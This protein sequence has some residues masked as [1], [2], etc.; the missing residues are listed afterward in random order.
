MS[1]KKW[2]KPEL[3]VL[4]RGRPEEAILDICKNT[5][6]PNVGPFDHHSSECMEGA[7]PTCNVCQTMSGT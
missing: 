3:V 1:K 5:G 6:V 4:V 7:G 2:E